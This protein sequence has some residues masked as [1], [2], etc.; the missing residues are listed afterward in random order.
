MD[1]LK[2]LEDD[3]ERVKKILDDLESTT[4]RGVK[5]REE[6][7]TRFKKE[8]QVHEVIEE[9]ILY[10][11]LTEHEKAKEIALEGYE[12]HHVVDQIMAE[13]DGLSYDDETWGA[14]FTVMKE[15]IEHHI[16]EEE[17]EMFKKARQIFSKDELE[18]MGERMEARKKQVEAS[19]A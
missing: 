12:E 7:Y 9:E 3:H 5:T 1:A 11:A 18:E 6:L 15:N 2:M 19:S 4:E 17:G 13:L 16:E 8:M 14:K 10:P